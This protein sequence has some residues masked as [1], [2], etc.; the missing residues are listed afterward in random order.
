MEPAD[1]AGLAATIM[2]GG[3]TGSAG[4]GVSRCEQCPGY[5]VCAGRGSGFNGQ[6]KP[7]EKPTHD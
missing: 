6:P 4:A 3:L 2:P 7:L 5:R 1:G